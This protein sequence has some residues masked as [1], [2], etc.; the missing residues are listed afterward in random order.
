[1]KDA[2]KFVLFFLEEPVTFTFSCAPVPWTIDVT[3]E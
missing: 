3:P 1:M 2:E